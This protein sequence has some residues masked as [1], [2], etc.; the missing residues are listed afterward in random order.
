ML[1]SSAIMLTLCCRVPVSASQE[2]NT[3]AYLERAD[4]TGGSRM[5]I[6]TP[7]E[8][9]SFRCD[10]Q[11]FAE[12]ADE[13]AYKHLSELLCQ[14][15]VIGALR[16]S[17]AGRYSFI[18]AQDIED[19]V[20]DALI[21]AIDREGLRGLWED[22]GEESDPE[23]WLRTKLR[24]KVSDYLRGRNLLVSLEEL[25]EEGIVVANL[26]SPPKLSEEERHRFWQA[27]RQCLNNDVDYQI[28]WLR[29]EEGLSWDEVAALICITPENARRRFD[30]AVTELSGCSFLRDVWN[31]IRHGH[32]EQ[33]PGGDTDGA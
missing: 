13:E 24:G 31:D 1:T 14:Q 3:Y 25:E 30:Y 18:P 17:V 10:L 32:S 15:K 23:I 7:Q 11:Q 27:I 21:R 12:S 33:I 5:G 16:A 2:T 19:I 6:F 22:Y 29:V 20:Q 4:T 28:V 8:I 9:D 26:P